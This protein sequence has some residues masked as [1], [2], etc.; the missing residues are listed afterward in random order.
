MIYSGTVAAAIE[1]AFLGLPSIAV[2]LYLR[3]EI[4]ADY[5]AHGGPRPRDDRA[6][7]AGGTARRAGAS[8]NIP[9]LRPT[10]SRPGSRWCRQCTR[11]WADTY[12]ERRDP[13][14]RHYFWNSSVFTLGDTEEDTDVAALR[15][16]YITDH[17]AAI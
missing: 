7:P 8:V 14:G 4:P 10:K 12:E 17:A 3:N 15:D 16:G 1:A 13:R 2:S 6:D 9:P 5:A 11:A